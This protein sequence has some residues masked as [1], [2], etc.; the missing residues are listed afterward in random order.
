MVEETEVSVAERLYRSPFGRLMSIIARGLAK[1]QKPFMVYGYYDHNSRMF[2]KFTRMSSTVTILNKKGLSVGDNVWVWHYTILDATEGL[3]I[4][5]G[6]QV[7]A[8][9]G[10][11]TDGSESSID[12]W[13]TICSY[14]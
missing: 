10:S 13:A 6:C 8:W 7:G 5:N 3:T 2:Q 4:E 14:S 9:V 1:F 11:S 12:C